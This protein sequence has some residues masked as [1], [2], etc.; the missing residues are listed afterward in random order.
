M[1]FALHRP[2]PGKWAAAAFSLL[3]HGVLVAVLYYGVQWQR[4]PPEAI[5]VELVRSLP[6]MAAP[7]PR[8]EP[9]VVKPEPV[10]EKPA[11]LPK[12]DIALKT[13]EKKKPEPK[14]EPKPKPEPKPEKKP[15]LKPPIEK[16]PE[17]RP[18]TPMERL[19]AQADEKIQA[20]KSKAEKQAIQENRNA[21]LDAAFAAAAQ[22]SALA[23]WADKIRQKV[24]SNLVKPPGV[25]GDPVVEFSI[26]L[27]PSGE[28]LGEPRLTKSSGS[29]V[30]DEAARRAIIK[31][32]PLPK[33]ETAEVFQR[34]ITFMLHPLRDRE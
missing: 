29:Q 16:K 5:S 24:K 26:E 4:R 15:E 19:M 30:L 2:E 33:P 10:V 32:S 23:G 6:P 21:K 34:Q 25:S 27:L 22:G 8:P 20:E 9:V 7:Q 1:E 11:P 31:S 13:P 14:V 12:P 17:P 28:I 18:L 3:M